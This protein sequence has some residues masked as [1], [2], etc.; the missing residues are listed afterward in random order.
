MNDYDHE[1][2]NVST[3]K[4]IHGFDISNILDVI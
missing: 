3:D 4:V 1:S 2:D